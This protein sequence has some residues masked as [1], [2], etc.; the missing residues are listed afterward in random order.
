MY[1]LKSSISTSPLPSSGGLAFPTHTLK[2]L[3]PRDLNNFAPRLGFAFTPTR[4]GKTVIRGAW[5]IYYDTVNG[6]LFID[7]RAKPGGRGVSRNPAGS[8]QVLSVTNE[9]Q[10]T[11]V[12]NAPIFG[13][14][15][16]LPPFGAY[17]INQNLRSPYVQNFSLN[18]QRQLTPRIVVQAGYVGSQGRKLIV[19]ENI[20]QPSASATAYPS[21]QAAR[22]FNSQFPNLSGITMISSVGN[23]QFNS[24]QLLVKATSWRGLSGQFG[25][26]LGHGRDDMSGARNN[27][28]T[29]NNN[30]R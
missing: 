24:M 7:N 8:N 6:N 25:Y 17:G 10:V 9:T 18:V 20:N 16:P 11:V 13:G 28:P 3:Y 26:T 29:D 19:T 5:G 1:E 12:Q 2:T 30:L 23:S 15:T 4:G 21:L 27:E 22:P 14:V